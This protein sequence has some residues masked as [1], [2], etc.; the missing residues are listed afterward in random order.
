MSLVWK[1][2]SILIPQRSTKY[3]NDG[4]VRA[5]KRYRVYNGF[6]QDLLDFTV[7]FE[8]RA[9]FSIDPAALKRNTCFKSDQKWP[10]IILSLPLPRFILDPGYILYR[11]WR[12]LW[13]AK[14]NLILVFE[15]WKK[16]KWFSSFSTSFFSSTVEQKRIKC[17]WMR[18]SFCKASF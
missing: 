12:G 11:V 3:R 13:P 15:K 8:T 1:F 9:Y 10:K 16:K 4:L 2:N 6:R 18:F 17:K 7:W 5:I 14:D